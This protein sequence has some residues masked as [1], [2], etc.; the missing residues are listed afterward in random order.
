MASQNGHLA[1]LPAAHVIGKAFVEQYYNILRLSPEMVHKFYQDVSLLGRPDLEGTMSSVTTMQGINEKIMSLKYGEYNFEIETVDAQH[2]FKEGVIVLVTGCLTGKANIQKKFTQSFFLAPQDN[3]GY[4]VL[5]DVFRY[6]S[7]S[8]A[9][10]D[11]NM[12]ENATHDFATNTRASP[13]PVSTIPSSEDIENAE[14]NQLEN[15]GSVVEEDLGDILAQPS[16]QDVSPVYEVTTTVQEDGPKK[17]YASIVKVMKGSTPAVYVPTTKAKVAP[18]KTE[19]Q[20]RVAAPV[21]T[22]ESESPSKNDLQQETSN[23]Q[24]E[25]GHAVYA[26]NLPLNA[27]PAQV[28]EEFKKFGTI[29]PGGVQ[30]RNHRQYGYCFG[31][32]EFESESSIGFECL[33]PAFM[34]DITN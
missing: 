13:D 20:V 14:V 1:S 4:F 15:L 34:F 18:I 22:V 5:N 9:K 16:E 25:E 29:K 10:E 11:N 27:T 23:S 7:K 30:V 33:H 3:G 8:Q 21:P 26:R 31:F 19:K 2:S 32:V 12:A 17:S 6:V 28:E 24:E